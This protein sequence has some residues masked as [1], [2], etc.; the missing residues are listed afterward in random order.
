MIPGVP[1]VHNIPLMRQGYKLVLCE[2]VVKVPL[3]YFIF[4]ESCQFRISTAKIKE[5]FKNTVVGYSTL[6]DLNSPADG[7]RM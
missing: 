4:V 1:Y 7:L 2:T 5:M 3:I 6:R